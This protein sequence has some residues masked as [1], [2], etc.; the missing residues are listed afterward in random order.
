MMTDSL[1]WTQLNPNIN[2]EPTRKQFYNQYLC[3]L[4]IDCPCGRLINDDPVDLKFA[5]RRR[6]EDSRWQNYG[7]SWASRHNKDLDRADVALLGA[8]IDIK[9]EFT[10]VKFR[11]EEPWVQIYAATEDT[12]KVVAERIPVDFRTAIT[13]IQLPESEEQAALLKENKILLSPKSK[14]TFKYKVFLKDGN[15]AVETKRQVLEY[16]RNLGPDAQVSTGTAMMLSKPYE[17]TWGCFV[18]VNDPSIL[19][20]L[21]IISPNMVSQIHEL[22]HVSK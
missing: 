22:T 21:N 9:K 8:L 1:Y 2:F 4:V 10:E 13:L 3:K 14:V 18:Y 6:V 7:G 20:F 17:Y 15:Y 11:V 16:L 19:T 5:L 12:L